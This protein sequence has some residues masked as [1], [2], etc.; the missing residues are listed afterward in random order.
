MLLQE[1]EKTR[2]QFTHSHKLCGGNNKVKMYA[3]VCLVMLGPGHVPLVHMHAMDLVLLLVHT[4]TH[5]SAPPPPQSMTKKLKQAN[6]REEE[7]ADSKTVADDNDKEM[8]HEG[9]ERS[10]KELVLLPQ[11]NSPAKKKLFDVKPKEEDGTS[12][13]KRRR[14]QPRQKNNP[15]SLPNFRGILLSRGRSCLM[16]CSRGHLLS[17][18]RHSLEHASSMVVLASIFFSATPSSASPGDGVAMRNMREQQPKVLMKQAVECLHTTGTALMLML[19]GGGG[20]P[21][22]FPFPVVVPAPGVLG[23]TAW[24]H[25]LLAAE[26]CGD[27]GDALHAQDPRARPSAHV[28]PR[29]GSGVWLQQQF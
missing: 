8:L 20:Q 9:D 10:E 28:S 23:R 3:C 17:P 6:K 25:L 18:H 4:N 19:R 1:K 16:V 14:R 26:G 13:P 7:V 15:R 2:Q 5:H 11:K 12:P 21:F 22:F 29:A 24:M 27:C